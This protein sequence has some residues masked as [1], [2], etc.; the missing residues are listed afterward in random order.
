MPDIM[1]VSMQDIMYS[2]K[3]DLRKRKIRKPE[4]E[5]NVAAELL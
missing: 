5:D 2:R 1:S 3:P 4:S